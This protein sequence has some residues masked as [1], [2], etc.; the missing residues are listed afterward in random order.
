[1]MKTKYLKILNLPT[2]RNRIKIYKQGL[3]ELIWGEAEAFLKPRS[4]FPAVG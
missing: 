4:R 2:L 3:I 1:M